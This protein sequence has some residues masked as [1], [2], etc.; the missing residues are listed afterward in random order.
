MVTKLTKTAP[1]KTTASK[2]KTVKTV[3]AVKKTSSIKN[4]EK[5]KTPKMFTPVAAVVA[6]I[7]NAFDFKSRATRSEFWWVMLFFVLLNVI[8]S[9]FTMLGNIASLLL[10]I[11]ILS[12][13]VR[14]LH[15]INMSG[16]WVAL[17]M[18]LIISGFMT[19]MLAIVDAEL[20][21]YLNTTQLS[22]G[23]WTV[24]ITYIV[25]IVLAILPSKNPNKYNDTG[26]KLW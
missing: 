24:L 1:K 21:G 16:W 19:S 14:R 23:A 25:S 6:L 12:L 26:I 9:P 7:R 15:D 8:L 3:K 22:I 11:P 17:F 4:N 13:E 20:Y 5:V 10:F 18:F 2:T